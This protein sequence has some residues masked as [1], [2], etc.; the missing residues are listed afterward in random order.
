MR[1]KQM[2]S[3]GVAVI[4]LSFGCLIAARSDAAP[5]ANQTLAGQ[6]EKIFDES[7]ARYATGTATIDEVVHWSERVYEADHSA[8]AFRTRA[9]KLDAQAQAK[10]SAGVA[11]KHDALVA[12]YHVT[13]AQLAN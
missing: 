8:A 13:E 9:T 6:A 2:V 1:Y 3:V 10:V 4:A 11:S 7:L 5:A 12:S